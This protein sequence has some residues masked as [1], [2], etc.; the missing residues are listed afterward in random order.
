MRPALLKHGL[1]IS[2]ALLIVT[3]CLIMFAS[4]P[5]G[6]Y[7]PDGWFES[8]SRLLQREPG[9]DNHTPVAV[10]AF[11][12]LALRAIVRAAGG[13][14]LQ[15][16]YAGSL[17]HNL[18]LAGSGLLVYATHRLLEM[19]RLGLLAGVGL[20]L[21]V[22]STL[23]TQVCWSENPSLFLAAA[24]FFLLVWLA[25]ARGLSR[26]R[27]AQ[28][29]AAIGALH[30]LSVMTRVVPILLLPLMVCFVWRMRGSRRGRDFGIIA[31]SVLA[32]VL[33]A[34]AAANQYRYGRFELATSTG[35]HLWNG[36]K[37]ISDAMLQESPSYQEW[38]LREQVLQGKA[39]WEFRTGPTGYALDVALQK[40]ILPGLARHPDLFLAHGLRRA[41]ACQ[42]RGPNQLGYPVL[43]NN[44][45][46]MP[47]LLPAP[48]V[49]WEDY[50]GFLNRICTTVD[51]HFGS[52]YLVLFALGFLQMLIRRDDAA[53]RTG[54]LF[55]AVA[56]F[57]PT[58]VNWI[59]ESSEPRYCIPYLSTLALFAS[60]SVS[61]PKLPARE[62]AASPKPLPESNASTGGEA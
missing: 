15:E 47:R 53:W 43:L 62:R 51:P 54:W 16:F 46:Q 37:D 26:R 33:V 56:Y 6:P 12:Y 38:K 35:R 57:L 14:L 25:T 24:T 55:F 40:M 8:S 7:T 32:A 61:R 22:Q 19:P 10:P 58:T 34:A 45:L 49:A 5:V 31:T 30:G 9:G 2:A 1:D 18:L 41:W 20:V 44:P 3:L 23:V 59:L 11:L 4:Q 27:A 28:L 36:L 17:A 13:G 52:A 21:L 42:Q 60:L 48:I 29:S 39:W 50:R